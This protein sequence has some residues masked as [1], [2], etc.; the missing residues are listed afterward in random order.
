MA[1]FLFYPPFLKNLILIFLFTW[2][3]KVNIYYLFLLQIM[4]VDQLLHIHCVLYLIYLIFFYNAAFFL[5]RIY[6]HLYFTVLI[7]I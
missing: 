6:V 4:Y 3:E 2:K 5:F 7:D 1:D